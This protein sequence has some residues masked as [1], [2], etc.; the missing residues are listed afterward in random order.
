MSE[1]YVYFTYESV[2]RD[3]GGGWA[4]RKVHGLISE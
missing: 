1:S 3:V 2:F 4:P